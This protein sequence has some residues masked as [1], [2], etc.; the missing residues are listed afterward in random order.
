VRNALRDEAIS[1]FSY[2]TPCLRFAAYSLGD[3]GGFAPLR[4]LLLAI[5]PCP[6]RQAA[7]Q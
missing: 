5:Y 7:S 4:E 6:N 1:S 3:L 2:E